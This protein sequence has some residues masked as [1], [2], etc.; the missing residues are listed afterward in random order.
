MAQLDAISFFLFILIFGG[1]ILT[2]LWNISFHGTR[3]SSIPIRA[4]M[5]FTA[6]WFFF[7]TT[8]LVILETMRNLLLPGIWS[9]ER[10]FSGLSSAIV[11]SSELE[12][13]TANSPVAEILLGW[14][15]FPCRVLPQISIDWSAVTI[16]IIIVIL[17]LILLF[18]LGRIFCG[19]KWRV[20]YG[21]A[22]LAAFAVLYAESISSIG[23]VRQLAW[24]FF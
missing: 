23:L 8:A 24:F 1:I 6:A 12:V 20:R 18:L 16:G 5:N 4:G 15:I 9:R 7:M 11:N 17:S 21:L 19:S 13:S 14:I 10:L 22:F 3:I 2:V